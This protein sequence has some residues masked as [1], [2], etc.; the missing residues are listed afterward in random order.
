[1]RKRNLAC[2]LFALLTIFF[3]CNATVWAQDTA[4]DEGWS[5]NLAPLYLWAISIDGD[6]TSGARKAPVEVSF[7]DIVDNLE[8]AFLIYFEAMHKDAWG[9]LF[10]YNALDVSNDVSIP[11]ATPLN[12]TPT[13]DIYSRLLEFSGLRRMKTGDH[14]FDAIAGFR[15]TRMKNELSFPT[16]PPLVSVT[17]SW[18]DPLVGLRWIWGFSDQW[19]LLVRGDVGGFGV[20][21]DFSTKG[22][23]L[24]DWQPFKHVSLLAGYRALYQDYEDDSGK[25]VFRFK[26]TIH[27]PVIGV[28]FRW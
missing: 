21:S 9:F 27:G 1:M 7:S 11:L 19:S 20:G 10:D 24:I 3:F 28:N 18:A 12:Y 15:Y 2:A 5:F 14:I 23:V 26:A 17:Q 13:V 6:I 25:E 4:D 16:G 8:A 22:S